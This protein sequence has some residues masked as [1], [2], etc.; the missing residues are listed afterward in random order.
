MATGRVTRSVLEGYFDCKYLAQLRLA[1]R[2]GVRSDYE[3]II[4]QLRRERHLAIGEVLRERHG[5]D[6]IIGLSISRSD[7]RQGTPFVLG[8]EI[9]DDTFQIRFDALKRV[10]GHSDL[11]PF[12]YVPVLF[13]ESRNVHR[14]HRLLL[15]SFGALITRVQKRPPSRGVIYHGD[16]CFATSVPFGSSARSGEDAIR[17]LARMHRGDADPPHRLN[18][19]CRICEFQSECRAKALKDDNLTLLRGLGEKEQRRYAH[20]GIFT[21]AQLSHTFRPRRPGKRAPPVRR[22]QYPLQALAIRDRTVYVLDK[23]ELPASP[24]EIFLDIEGKPDEQF[25]YL[26]GVIVRRGENEERHSFWADRKDE[27]QRIFDQLIALLT[28]HPE[29]LIF[30]YGAYEHAFIRRMRAGASRKKPID[31]MLDRLVNVLAIVYPHFYF[32]TYTNGLK[33]IGTALGYKWHDD[34][35]SGMQSVAWRLRWERDRAAKLKETLLQYNLD[36]CGALAAVIA[37]LR[38]ASRPQDRAGNLAAGPASELKV[39]PVVELAK[40]R[41]TLPWTT[42]ENPDLA[43]VNK[44]AHFDYQRQRVHVRGDARL[45][46]RYLGKDTSKNRKLRRSKVVR[47]TASRC[48]KCGANDIDPVAKPARH[49][50]RLPRRKRTFDLRVTRSSLKRRVVDCRATVYACRKC[51]HQFAPLRYERIANHSHALMC[52]VIYLSVAHRV[53]FGAISEIFKDFFGVKLH[54]MEVLMFRSLLARYYRP[55]YRAILR[56]LTSGPLLHADETEVRHRTG[57][58]YVWTFASITEAVYLYRPNRE[59]AF[60]KE[61][62]G[63]FTGVLV[64]DFYAVYDSLACPQQKCLIHLIRDLNQEVLTHPF[65]AELQSI[66]GRFGAL[67]RSIVATVDQHGLRRRHLRRHASPVAQFF[68]SLADESLSSEPAQALRTRLLKNRGRLFTFLEHDDVP[69]NNNAAENAI[70]RFAYFRDDT[71]PMTREEGLKDYL[72]LLSLFQTCR[73]KAVNFWRFLLSRQK[74]ID[75]FAAGASSRGRRDLD[76]YP[77]GFEPPHWKRIRQQNVVHAP[78]EAGGTPS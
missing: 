46:S 66:V 40:A 42:F 35:A 55:T 30:A 43:F 18:D 59:G 8:A 36:D 17:D 48:P 20:R 15:A 31:Q 65:D 2:E 34:R 57:T 72:V 51:G 47:I 71:A 77:P 3:D 22:R 5:E 64:S 1:G 76:L 62:L 39:R 21:L 27:E 63:G 56:R 49:L 19:H 52:W 53:S 29:A 78:R 45:R 67:L 6:C 69:W 41:Y 68:E 70:R 16:P 23:P 14:W 32:P 75:A 60:L 73:Y 44:C 9:R 28:A 33:E 24:I 54:P 38:S 7:L 61:M 50:G 37:F 25:V 12:H 58:G 26:I 10:E 74:D 4:I 11:G 13:S